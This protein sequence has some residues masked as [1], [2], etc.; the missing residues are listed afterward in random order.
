[1]VGI[2][3]NQVVHIGMDNIHKNGVGAVGNMVQIDQ[4]VELVVIVVIV[5]IAGS[6]VVVV[7]VVVA[8]EVVV[9]IPVAAV[10]AVGEQ[11]KGARSDYNYDRGHEW[12]DRPMGCLYHY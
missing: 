3:D 12:L 11:D 6:V 2:I 4:V 10:V 5:V 8:G 9:D 1:V 7:V